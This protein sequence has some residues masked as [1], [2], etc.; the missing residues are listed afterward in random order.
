MPSP[1]PGPA[2][3]AVLPTAD[4]LVALR[5]RLGELDD[6]QQAAGLAG[7]DEQTKMPPGAAAARGEVLSTLSRLA[8]ARLTDDD[9]HALLQ[10][11]SAATDLGDQDRRLVAAVARDADRA[12]RVPERLVADITRHTTTAQVAW[13][14]ARAAGDY[15]PFRGPLE[16]HV[17][18]RRELV[19]CFPEAAHP[20]DVLLHNFEPD[21]TTERVTAVFAQLR[22][23]LVPLIRRIADKPAPPALPGPFPVEQQRV[24][25]MEIARAQG[26]DDD[27]WRL[28]DA[29][30]PFAAALGSSDIRVTARYDDQTLTGLFAVMHEVGHGLYERQAAPTLARTTV[31]TGVS[32]GIHESQSRLWE[33]LVGRSEA[34]WSH[35][36][37]RAVELFG[38]AALGGDDLAAFLKAINV[39]RPSLVRVEA[40]EATYS[41]HVIL[42]FEL[43]VA[44]MEGTLAVA[45]LDAAWNTKTRELLGLDVPS[46][47]VGVLQDIHWAYGEL[48]YFPT[49]AIGNIVAAQLWTVIERDLTDLDADLAAGETSRL[50]EWLREHVHR[51]GRLYSPT[52]LLQQ[53][54]GSGLDA[55]P[56]LDQLTAK[57][58]ALYDLEA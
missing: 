27:H 25:G 58:S 21:L 4:A 19:A 53:I 18:Y 45:D 52:E 2:T 7:W 34:F 22:D 13:Q 55:Q 8:H 32:L 47:T 33:N 5:E 6:L 39:V 24:L 35:W 37:P 51:H 15:A 26:F 57:Y 42:R 23:G 12:R 43:E 40:D 17:A 46:P 9:L 20:Y 29:I 38:A 48:G 41:L 44:L 11:L 49:Y 16:Q 36:H 3:P 14:E 30:H 54:T 56:F 28:D 50:R 31:G 10:Q 1:D